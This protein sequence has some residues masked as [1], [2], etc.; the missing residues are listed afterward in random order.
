MCIV[1]FNLMNYYIPNFTIH[2]VYLTSFSSLLV[3]QT[4][5][6]NLKSRSHRKPSMSNRIKRIQKFF[7]QDKTAFLVP[8]L[9]EEALQIH[10]RCY[11]TC[12]KTTCIHFEGF[13]TRYW[14]VLFDIHS[15][16][17]TFTTSLLHE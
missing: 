11:V 8:H 17:G 16:H 5:F 15:P 10:F 4:R 7:Q 9:L 2:F 6:K 12:C 1:F 3:A 14:A 13:L